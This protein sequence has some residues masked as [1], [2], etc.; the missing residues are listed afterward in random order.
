MSIKYYPMFDHPI[1]GSVGHFL[2]EACA[3]ERKLAQ[4]QSVVTTCD[5]CRKEAH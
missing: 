4:E 2:C 5:E 3:G 1:Y